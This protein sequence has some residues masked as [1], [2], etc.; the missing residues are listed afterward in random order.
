VNPRFHLPLALVVG[1]LVRVPFWIEALKTPVD[2]DTA[3]VGLMARHLGRGTTLWGQPYGSPLDAWVAAPFVAAMGPTTEALRLPYFLLGLALIPIVYFLARGLDSRAAL[4]AALLMACPPPYFL[5]LSSLPP[6]FYATSLVLAGLLLVLALRLG[7]QLAVG[8]RPV[9][10]L[11]VWGAL[12]GLALWTH[13]MVASVVLAAAVYL[14]WRGREQP[15]L[16]LPAALALL[17]AS[18]PSWT[19][20]LLEGRQAAQM[21]SL[22]GRR[23]TM[24]SH[25]GEVLPR[26]HEPLG[27]LLGARVPLVADDPESMIYVSGWIA[28]G[29]ILIYGVSMIQAVR[30]ARA[31]PTAWL[32]LGVIVLA[33]A[34]FS[35]PLRSSPTSLRFLSLLY[36]P[37]AA[38]TAWAPVARVSVRRAWI[39]VLLLACLHLLGGLRLLSAWRIAD[40]S[41]PPYLLPDLTPVRKLLDAHGIR[42]AY[43]SYGPA[44]RLTYESGERIIASQPWNERFLHYPLPYL[45]EVRFGKNVAWVL[46][47]KVPTDLPSPRAFENALGPLAGEWKRAEVGAAVVY[48]GFVPPFEPTGE[49]LSVAGFPGDGSL[50]TRLMPDPARPLTLTLPLPRALDAVTLLAGLD[51]PR[52]L[53][54]MDVEVSAD[55]ASFETVARRRRREERSDLRWVNGHPQYVLDHDVLAIPLGGRTVAAVRIT[56]VAST[57]PWAIGEI[58]LHPAADRAE[59]RPWDEW[60]D[61]NLGWHERREALAAKPLRDREDWYSRTLLAA[62]AR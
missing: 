30:S 57:D 13:L 61:P 9:L 18:A 47:P 37:W 41:A 40:R 58:L 12:A 36:L 59:R 48:H 15:R 27:G 16:L 4:P 8:G 3:I 34:A 35:F 5:L 31:K 26:L 19:R 21:V 50:E 45:D 54:S 25:L 51:G 32:Y 43:A 22:S 53:R 7:L 14:V 49:P 38:L 10:W 52:L 44:Y 23:E 28:F 20:V 29:L 60:L 33:L 42:R 24:L 6:P 39:V 17:G 11:V 2:G 1:L 56:P 62:R 55:G 46:T